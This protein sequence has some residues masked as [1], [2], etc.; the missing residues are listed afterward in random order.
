VLKRAF[1]GESELAFETAIAGNKDQRARV[2]RLLSFFN[3]DDTSDRDEL[4]GLRVLSTNL[5]QPILS[6]AQAVVETGDLQLIQD[7]SLRSAIIQYVGD[8]ESYAETQDAMLSEIRRIQTQIE[9]T[10]GDIP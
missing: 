8:G 9:K 4:D 5:T 2:L 6:T 3:E 1:L 7:D 10:S